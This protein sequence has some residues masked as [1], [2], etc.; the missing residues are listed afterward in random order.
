MNPPDLRAPGEAVRRDAVLR[1]YVEGR[2]WDVAGES[3]LRRHLVIHSRTLLPAH[4]L[5][6]GL[7][8]T[9][10]LGQAGDLLFFD[11]ARSLLVVELKVTEKKEVARR[12]HKVDQQALEFARA[13]RQL[14]PWAVVEPRVYTSLEQAAGVG[15]APPRDGRPVPKGYTPQALG[16]PDQG[17]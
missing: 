3:L 14:F 1:A 16:H 2:D 5:L 9:A 6:V 13:A 15:P 17:D 8:W 4:P 12:A 10:R 11:G 7:E